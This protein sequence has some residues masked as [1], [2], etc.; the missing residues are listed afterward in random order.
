[1]QHICPLS[2]DGESIVQHVF[3]TVGD[4]VGA[5]LHSLSFVVLFE[6]SKTLPSPHEVLFGVQE[7]AEVGVFINV[8]EGH[9][10]QS[11]SLV[12]E[13]TAVKK[14]PEG[15]K[16]LFAVHDVE[17]GVENVPVGHGLQEGAP[18]VTLVLFLNVPAGHC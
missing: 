10:V 11:L 9:G 12:A 8:P 5:V 7:V 2:Q 16:V 1:M 17:P 3:N 14:L 15:Q 13:G 18:A 6:N 4:G